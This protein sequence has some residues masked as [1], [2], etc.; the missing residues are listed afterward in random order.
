MVHWEAAVN[1]KMIMDDG[2]SITEA[3]IIFVLM[4]LVEPI[5]GVGAFSRFLFCFIFPLFLFLL[6]NFISFFILENYYLE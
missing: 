5:L 1:F 6:L 2:S 4:L 3:Q